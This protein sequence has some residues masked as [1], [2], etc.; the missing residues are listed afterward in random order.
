[1][2]T[3]ARDKHHMITGIVK[4]MCIQELVQFNAGYNILLG[5]IFMHGIQS[6]IEDTIYVFWNNTSMWLVIVSSEVNKIL[7]MN[8][9]YSHF[10]ERVIC[11]LCFFF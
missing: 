7:V 4:T 3:T 2:F 10:W 5:F 1:M 9:E 6:M 11:S 8:P